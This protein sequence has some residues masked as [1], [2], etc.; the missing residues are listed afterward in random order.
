[1]HFT[2]NLE[3]TIKSTKL[4]K[5]RNM[6]LISVIVPVYKVEDYLDRCVESI[7]NQ[8]YKNLEIILVDDGSPD[9]CPAMCDEWAKKDE[10][11]RVVHVENG[12][13]GKARNIGIGLATGQ[14]ISFVDS[15]D[16]LS[17]LFFENMIHYFGDRVDVVECDYI[18]TLDDKCKLN[19][20]TFDNS[21]RVS[22][23]K[24]M[25]LHI[26][27]TAFKQV[28]W[29][30]VYRRELVKNV[31]FPEGKTIDDE[32]W[33]YQIIGNSHELV[34]LNKSLYAYRQ[35]NQSIMHEAFSWKRLEAIEAKV[36]RLK[37]IELHYD[38]LVQ[39]AKVN[40]W[41]TSLYLGQMSLNNLS[42]NECKKAFELI[43][44]VL[45]RYSFVKSEL[46]HM[47]YSHKLWVFM[48]RVSVEKTCALRN[49]L[50]I[51]L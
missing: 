14:Y 7:V 39:V 47:K 41:L 30:K 44:G 21:Y 5:G 46:R 42:H 40:L 23:E 9:R 45:K 2:V 15:D 8:T 10:R 11:I 13:A 18:C 4:I 31:R 48:T 38:K 35:Q 6:E 17:E 27:D 32:F 34:H 3:G 12:G 49:C 24:A 20:D 1:M 50:K 37:Y 25:E 51:G 29:N 22:S 43:E 19:K 28:I 26:L 36:E 16:Y 33:T